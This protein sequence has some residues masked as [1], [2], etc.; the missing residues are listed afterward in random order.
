[1][2]K[3]FFSMAILAMTCMSLLTSCQKSNADLIKDYENLC[4]EIVEATEAGN[5][6]KVA[7]LSDKGQKLE[8]ELS[9]RN[10][11]DEEKAQLLEIQ[12]NVATGVVSGAAKGVGNMLESAAGAA[13]EISNSIDKFDKLMNG[14]S[15]D[16]K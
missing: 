7:T 16:D 12:A 9:N 3:I 11:T 6:V 13:K 1:M 15:D 4:K 10:L 14:D 2:K 8:Q 5:L